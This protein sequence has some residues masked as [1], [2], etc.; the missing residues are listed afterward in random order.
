MRVRKIYISPKGI[1]LSILVLISVYAW[2]PA[3]LGGIALYKILFPICFF[4]FVADKSFTRNV[5]G[6]NLKR[7]CLCWTCISIW[8]IIS[9]LWIDQ[10]GNE[11]SIISYDVSW[12]IIGIVFSIFCLN[13]LYKEKLLEYFCIFAGVIGIMGLYTALTGFY[14][15][16]TYIS[17]LYRRNFLNLYRPNGIFYN[18]NDH[19]VFMFFSLVILFIMTER[20]GKKRIWRIV[21]T[22]I[23]GANILLVDS[24]GV[25][26]ARV[27]FLVLYFLNTRQI[28]LIWKMVIWILVSVCILV[29]FQSIMQISIFSTGVEDSGRLEIMAMCLASL[30]DTFFM[31]VGPGNIAAVNAASFS[32][33]TVAPHNFFVELFCDYGFVGLF[34]IVVWFV[35]M[36]I[37]AYKHSKKTPECIVIW[38]ALIAFLPISIVSSSLIGKSWVACF[39][40]ILVAF[41]NSIEVEKS[42]SKAVEVKEDPDSCRRARK[43]R[44]L[45]YNKRVI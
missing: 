36:F 39:F 22:I 42:S 15:N 31:G 41:L 17:Y 26:L 5:V 4:I 33:R 45:N 35:G 23:F 11:W 10:T 21:G 16:V 32:E 43:K 30:E 29:N 8:G 27:V 28:K 18:V 9:L 38:I 40:G 3:V 34:C 1:L 19:A 6:A 44:F 20:Q 12:I 7:V 13:K 14:F 24:R 25:E 37:C 2:R